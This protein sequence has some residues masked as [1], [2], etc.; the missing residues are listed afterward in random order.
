MRVPLTHKIPKVPETLDLY[1]LAIDRPWPTLVFTVTAEDV[2]RWADLIDD[3]HPW[4][5]GPSPWG[6]PVAP[7]SIFYYPGQSAFAPRRDFAGVL[8]A[9]GFDSLAPVFVG[10]E[11]TATTAITDRYARRGRGFVAWSQTI[12]DGDVV[13]ARSRRTWAF[14]LPDDL[15]ERFPE[16]PSAPVDEPT[17]VDPLPP[18]T[19]ELSLARLAAFEGPGERNGHTDLAIAAKHG[20]PGALAQG[21]LAVSPICRM[22][23][24]RFGAGWVV[25]GS[26]DVKVV[27]SSFSGDVVQS[28][29]GVTRYENGRAICR[30][31]VDNVTR[32]Q[33]VAVGVASA[34]VEVT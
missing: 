16:R 13:V 3:P 24:A 1:W 33:R 20:H 25:G 17:M 34:V 12:R 14:E 5:F 29:G 6:G 27:A 26:M 15:R 19:L 32:A 2:A 18:M 8:S 9:I 23:R 21:A 22:M 11:L 31:W 10:R 30:V 7:S 4:H 28:G